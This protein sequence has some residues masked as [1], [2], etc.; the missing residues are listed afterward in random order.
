LF[1]A[2]SRQKEE[3][4][5]HLLDRL[6]AEIQE[7]L[8]RDDLMRSDDQITRA[9][10]LL[11][12][13]TVLLAL[14]AE[15]DG[16]RRE[17]ERNEI[18]GTALL[19]SQ[20]L[21]TEDPA[22]ALNA[23]E[24][25]LAKVGDNAALLQ[26]RQRLLSHLQEINP[27]PS[28]K[29]IDT[30]DETEPTLAAVTNL[31]QEQRITA[32]S[33]PTTPQIERSKISQKTLNSF[34]RT[35]SVTLPRPQVKSTIKHSLL[36]NYTLIGGMILFA[37]GL[38]TV[39]VHRKHA[40]SPVPERPVSPTASPDLTYLE[41]GASPW[42]TVLAVHDPEGKNVTLPAKVQTTPLRV[43]GLKAGEYEVVLRG[44]DG[45]QKTVLCKLTPEDHLCAGEM[46]AMDIQRLLEGE[47]P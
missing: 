18:V 25:G 4:R 27:E 11:P 38:A 10:D 7:S 36:R 15:M 47:R 43:E 33:V 44:P 8:D 28:K 30:V 14:R 1:T 9:L 42:A 12:G 29:V 17:T 5:Q 35:P 2:T 45:V 16:R 13:E 24:A 23:V 41:I 46:E 3:R 22:G 32:D 21:F 40:Q 20:E 6:V 34:D 19:R 31:R 37:V 26:A 39:L